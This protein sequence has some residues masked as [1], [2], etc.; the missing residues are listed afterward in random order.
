MPQN[1]VFHIR[2]PKKAGRLELLDFLRGA[3]MLLVLLHH[4]EVP[5]AYWILAF[6]MPLLF[7]LSG[8]T[9]SRIPL[10]ARF[11]D[12]LRSRFLRLMIPYF[13]FEGINLLVWSLSLFLQG[14]WQDVS[15]AV[16][17][18]V[19]CV[20]TEGYTGYYG[21]LW[22]WPCMFVSDMFFYC[23][24]Q[25]SPRSEKARYAFQ[26]GMIPVLFGISW[27]TCRILPGRLPFTV[28]TAFM[29]SNK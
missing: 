23:V 16:T 14:G 20:N 9:V 18:I 8:Y 12:F 4:S 2:E 24:L 7:L 5:K 10:K 11:A 26:F 15:E 27:V 6:H 17:A 29:A 22:F 1:S 19:S 28:D 3:G 13:L 21:R 25:Y